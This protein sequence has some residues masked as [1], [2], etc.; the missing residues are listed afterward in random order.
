MDSVYAVVRAWPH[1]VWRAGSSGMWLLYL[2]LGVKQIF[3]IWTLELLCSFIFPALKGRIGQENGNN[4]WQV[5]HS[6]SSACLH[7]GFPWVIG[8]KNSQA[9][10]ERRE[11]YNQV[12]PDFFFFNW[13]CIVLIIRNYLPSIQPEI[14][15]NYTEL[16]DSM[17]LRSLPTE[18][19]LWTSQSAI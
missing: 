6:S 11:L 10:I 12:V 3:V 5:C 17:I 2:A 14:L 15:I 16:L 13:G 9:R 19:I 7:L 18:M 4:V 1:L 8:N